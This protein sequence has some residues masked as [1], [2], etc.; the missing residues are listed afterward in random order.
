MISEK[1]LTEMK[2]MYKGGKTF[3]EIGKAYGKTHQSIHYL[4]QR[5]G[6]LISRKQ[7]GVTKILDKDALISLY[8]N[9]VTV[10][11]IAALLGCSISVV[12]YNLKYYSI[13]RRKQIKK[14]TVV[15]SEQVLTKDFLT[16]RYRLE[17]KTILEIATET[18]FSMATV[19]N[20]LKKF[21][22]NKSSKH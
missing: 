12:D 20:K 14:P 19:F 7:G 3:R 8:E 5:R 16:Q 6:L 13:P 21:G 2:R 17:N 1:V 4:F 11:D 9:N 22:L 10:K 18:G 15:K